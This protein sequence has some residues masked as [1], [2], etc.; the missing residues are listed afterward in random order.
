[1]GIAITQEQRELARSVRGWLARTV[2]PEEVRK[3]LDVPGA[4]I[5]RPVHWD[6]AAG[7]GLLGVH[8]P[9]EYGGGAGDLVDLAVVLEETGRALLPGPCLPTTLAAEILRRVADQRLRP[10]VDPTADT[11]SATEAGAGEAARLTAALADGSRIAAVA[12]GAGTL[13]AVATDHGL[14]LDGTAPPSSRADRP[15]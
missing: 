3:H 8:L 11:A 9:E 7:Q 1:M 4:T 5:G 13:T 10:A 12:L 6:A 2:P 15:T 14:L